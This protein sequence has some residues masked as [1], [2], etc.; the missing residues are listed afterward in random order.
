M[1]ELTHQLSSIEISD[2]DN[3]SEI[4][5]YEDN[6]DYQYFSNQDSKY[7]FYHPIYHKLNTLSD[8]RIINFDEAAFIISKII[9]CR[10]F[11]VE[12]EI[13]EIYDYINGFG[14]GV[15]IQSYMC[16]TQREVLRSIIFK[17]PQNFIDDQET[18]ISI[19]IIL[20]YIP[21]NHIILTKLNKY[22]YKF[23]N[24]T[25]NE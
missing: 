22:E 14:N 9:D 23:L 18:G 5:N 15:N 6:S 21:Y 16:N 25:Y 4:T 24:Y 10:G 17:N 20:G 3:F 11:Y 8:N 7:E 2:N 19:H 1:D 12:N 13:G